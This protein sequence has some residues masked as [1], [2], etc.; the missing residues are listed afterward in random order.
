MTPRMRHTQSMR[1]TAPLVTAACCLAAAAAAGAAPSAR[2]SLR[3]VDIDP[4]TLRGAG[5][6]PGERVRLT[7]HGRT[8]TL[9]RSA[10]TTAAGTFTA[11]FAEVT[12]RERCDVVLKATA[13]GT[14]GD[15][16]SARFPARACPVRMDD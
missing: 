5:F 8:V 16:A 3:L 1:R 10:K 7:F 13:A 14:T 11:R 6:A 9:T 2:P 12:D 4:V 15:R